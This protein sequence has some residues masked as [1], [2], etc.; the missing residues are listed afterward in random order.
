MA[1]RPPIDKGKPHAVPPRILIA[2]VAICLALAAMLV[3]RKAELVQRL[4]EDGNLQRARAVALGGNAPLPR[5]V[6]VE[7]EVKLAPTP[8]LDRL[9]AV[10]TPSTGLP[11]DVANV[12]YE[13]AD[14]EACRR[15]VHELGGT[16]SPSQLEKVF[17]AM[18]Q[19]ALAEGKAALAAEIF[20]EARSRGFHSEALIVR[21]VQACRWSGQP[22]AALDALTE[23]QREA[24][25]P[26][27]L[28]EAHLGLYRELNQPDHALDLLIKQ[29]QEQ[30]AKGKV[31]A[32]TVT[33]TT[34]VAAQAGQIQKVLPMIREF[35]ATLP[36]AQADLSEMASGS[37]TPDPL[38]TK[39]VK[40]TAQQCEWGGQ[41]LE[42]FRFY[43]KLAVTGDRQALDRMLELNLGLRR[44]GE[45]LEVLKAVVP[46]PEKP[47][48][49]LKLA[50]LL[51]NAGEADL[52]DQHFAAW[53]T[54]HPGAIDVLL[55]RAALAE[56]NS[57]QDEALAMYQLAL[58][59]DGKNL[60]IKKAIASLHIARH[61][62]EEAFDFYHKLPEEDHDATTLENYALVAESLAR[63]EAL[64]HA[65]VE[66]QHRLKK[67]VAH[68]YLELGRSFAVIGDNAG[69]ID[70][71]EDGL[72]KIP[73][74]HILRI[75]LANALRFE[76]RYD[77][78]L[79]LLARPELKRDMQAMQLYIEVACLKEDYLSALNFLGRGFEHKFAFGPE[80]RLDLGHIYFNNGYLTEADALYSSVPDEPALW[81]LLAN[82]RFKAGDF[83]SAETYQ[84]KYL[85][86][87][88]IPDS[89][90]WMFMGD[91]YRA[92]GRTQEA[93]MA[94][95]KSLRLLEDKLATSFIAPPAATTPTGFSQSVSTKIPP[96]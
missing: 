74:S 43:Q 25:L 54:T 48:L 47:E 49:T 37:V 20:L 55:E 18:G 61:E 85:T 22:Q 4:M 87:L 62:F 28:A 51:A 13:V 32:E 72:K 17:L 21:L 42:A 75:E 68:D 70:T 33:L 64:N 57:Q 76:N 7:V 44:D 16:I 1:S 77:E 29:W 11:R 88:Q 96:P 6:E 95:A 39:F 40:L 41:P 69:A 15:V 90:G 59:T 19:S 23:Y 56:E 14:A 31:E 35:L 26:V 66:R 79:A 58:A 34:E 80:V 9:R 53:L 65:L 86:S 71:Y 82:A 84:K 81:P 8:P 12:V 92:L 3:P 30:T 89:S 52:A 93:Q 10:L 83:A 46:I 38:W 27:A 73:H 78:A 36:A 94:Y 63:Y 67:P 60:Q 24:P 5:E 50:R 2:T 91:I 45:L